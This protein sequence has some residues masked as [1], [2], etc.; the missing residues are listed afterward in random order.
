MRCNQKMSDR[1]SLPGAGKL[2]IFQ[3]QGRGARQTGFTLIELLAVIAIIGILAA[4]MIGLSP[5]ASDK[6]KASLID[7]QKEWLV[8]AI[9]SY[10]AKMGTYPPDNANNIHALTDADTYFDVTAKNTLL[11]ELTG[12]DIIDMSADPVFRL[13]DAATIKSSELASFSGVGGIANSTPTYSVD[14][15]SVPFIN[16][17]PKSSQCKFY[18]G[19]SIKGLVVPV[20]LEKSPYLD[21]TSQFPA[22]FVN[23]WHYDCSSANRH[24]PDSFDIW[25]VYTMGKGLTVTNGNWIQK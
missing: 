7:A 8:S 3:G 5:L 14:Q 24:N 13:Y 9:E 22:N 2:L 15:R 18:P 6:R 23:F 19:F 25:A 10:K 21:T 1:E 17:A 11:Y 16:P 12:A 4:L 20:A